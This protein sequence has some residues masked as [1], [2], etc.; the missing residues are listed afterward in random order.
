VPNVVNVPFAQAEADVYSARL[1]P[2]EFSGAPTDC[3]G[4]PIPKG[5]FIIVR[6]DPV[7]GSVLIPGATVNLYFCAGSN[8]S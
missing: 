6:Q 5:T 1:N 7:P 8:S 4:R 3:A 2:Q